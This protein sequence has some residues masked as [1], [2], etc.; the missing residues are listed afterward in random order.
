MVSK[1]DK[2][3][4]RRTGK[5]KASEQRLVMRDDDW[6][7][8]KLSPTEVVEAIR[9]GDKIITRAAARMQ[10]QNEATEIVYREKLY[11]AGIIDA[12]LHFL[13]MC[14]GPFASVDL[15]INSNQRIFKPCHWVHLLNTMTKIN[16][17]KGRFNMQIVNNLGPLIKCMCDTKKRELFESK[18]QW[19]G[20]LDSFVRILGNVMQDAD[21]GG[22]LLKIDGVFDMLLQCIFIKDC[23]LDIVK[24]M[25]QADYELAPDFDDGGVLNKIAE[26]AQTLILQMNHEHRGVRGVRSFTNDDGK[27]FKAMATTPIISS[28]TNGFCS[29][30][31]FV[32]LIA[33]KLKKND[34]ET[35][36]FCLGTLMMLAQATKNEGTTDKEV[37]INVMNFALN[38]VGSFEDAMLITMTI[39]SIL[40]PRTG[41]FT[42]VSDTRVAA[43]ISSGLLELCIDFAV[44]YG[45]HTDPHPNTEDHMITNLWHLASSAHVTAL[46]K[47]SFKAINGRRSSIQ[48]ALSDLVTGKNM[49]LPAGD[50]MDRSSVASTSENTFIIGWENKYPGRNA[51]CSEIIQSVKA[52]L[53]LSTTS[54]CQCLKTIRNSAVKRCSNCQRTVYC[55]RECQ[56]NHWK[57]GGHKWDCKQMAIANALTVKGDRK[58]DIEK[59][60]ELEGNI[61]VACNKLVLE[62]ITRILVQAKHQKFD[63]L[64]CIV[65]VELNH[66]LPFVKVKLATDSVLKEVDI[67]LERFDCNRS[68]GNLTCVY[69]SYVFNGEAEGSRHSCHDWAITQL[70]QTFP[71]SVA[72]HGSWKKAQDEVQDTVSTGSSLLSALLAEVGLGNSN[73]SA[74]IN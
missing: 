9:S 55:S 17:G 43:A 18:A 32:H 40:Q 60:Y 53:F 70:V 61:I 37:I 23:R 65:L 62:N 49:Y 13:S 25:K 44:R 45:E 19:Y 16:L 30:T 24:E 67:E 8:T 14:E 46:H 63:I 57:T 6:N 3:K 39:F 11:E 27:Y 12:L 42:K 7:I 47:R 22:V 48:K 56:V 10:T 36:G 20:S 59:A 73:E 66:Q 35:R 15:S 33:Q 29:T 52:A 28:T 38:S 34:K 71:A 68:N 26:N 31:P 50:Q 5:V 1:K 4:Q 74:N 41:V 51:R 58:K 72:S 69:K 21:A 2:K 64:D 54:C